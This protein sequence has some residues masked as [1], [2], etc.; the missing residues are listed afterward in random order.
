MEKGWY[1]SGVH[2]ISTSCTGSL[3]LLLSLFGISY[4][5]GRWLLV[6]SWQGVACDGSEVDMS[7]WLGWTMF[8]ATPFPLCFYLKWASRARLHRM[9]WLA[10]KQ[11]SY[12]VYV[13][14]VGA[15]GP[16]RS[17]A[18]WFLSRFISLAQ[19]SCWPTAAP[20][21]PDA[22]AASLTPGPGVWLAP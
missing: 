8:P 7:V 19:G 2:G 22:P 11:Q 5:L 10:R 6:L 3:T 12:C 9:R 14:K 15:G 16:G 17:W 21:S 20:P 18:L 1:V 4:G 13:W